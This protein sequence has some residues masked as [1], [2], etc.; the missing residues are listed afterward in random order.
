MTL[1][2]FARGIAQHLK[3]WR[4]DEMTSSTTARLAADGE[5]GIYLRSSTYDFDM[6]KSR[7][8]VTGRYPH[9]PRYGHGL[10]REYPKITAAARRG[11]GAIARDIERR[12][13]PDY[14][15]IYQE[16]LE[17]KRGYEKQDR[18]KERTLDELAGILNVQ[19]GQDKV[20][21]NYPGYGYIEIQG[22]SIKFDLRG[23]PKD[24]A[25]ELAR[26]LSTA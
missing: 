3:G 4:L 2:E 1:E 21:P 12:F 25:L 15:P 18:E 10:A 13:L 5:Q 26:V 9:H 17:S 19:R 6:E 24:V 8:E 23:V 14:L 11:P 7:I 16:A 22:G 20:Y